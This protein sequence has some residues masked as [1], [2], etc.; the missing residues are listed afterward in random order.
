MY[1][2]KRYNVSMARERLADVL[3]EAD[4]NGAVLIERG[5]VQYVITVRGPRRRPARRTS[6]IETVDRAV[7]EGEWRW[8]VTAKGLRFGARRQRS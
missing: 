4:R 8:N 3:N 6:V 1:S 7:S 5:D 2:V